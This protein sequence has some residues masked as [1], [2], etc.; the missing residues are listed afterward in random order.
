VRG[1]NLEAIT[2]LSVL[3]AGSDLLVLRHPKTLEHIRKYLAGLM[4]RTDLV[5][6]GLDLSLPAPT[7]P[8][9]A[10]RAAAVPAA[11]Q[12]RPPEVAIE[13][14]EAKPEEEPAELPPSERRPEQPTRPEPLP[15]A[16]AAPAP[17]R[18]PM[19]QL[20]A[21]DIQGL[22]EMVAVFKAVKQLIAGVGPEAP[23]EAPL[24]P[25]VLPG[26]PAAKEEASVA[27]AP[28][29]RKETGPVDRSQHTL[30]PATPEG[31][32]RADEEG[33]A[34]A[35]HHAQPRT[36]CAIDKNGTC[37]K[38]CNMG[39]CCLM[40]PEGET[41]T[42]EERTERIGLCGAT[43]ET[44]AARNFARMI[45]AGSAAH[46]DHGRHVAHT[47]LYAAKGEL[48][49]YQI[50][51]IPKL[52]AVA[53]DLGVG[54]EGRE[55][56]DIAVEVGEKALSQYGRQDGELLYIKRAPL[57]LQEIWR[58]EGV[59]PP[60]IDRSV[61]EVMNI[62][63]MAVNQDMEQVV[64]LATECALADGW[65]ASMMATD[66]SD[67]LFGT[68]VP[69]LGK[70]NL[71]YMK[72]DTVNIIVHGHEPSLSEMIVQ[73]VQDP[74]MIAYAKSKGALG[75]I[76]LGGICCTSDEILIRH[77]IPIVGN[78]LQQELAISTGALEA[79]VVDVQSV[80]QGVADPAKCFHTQIVT[81]GPIAK[82]Q[83]AY[84]HYNYDESHALEIARSIVR[85]AIDNFPKRDKARVA[86]PAEQQE[87]VVGFSHEAIN[88]ML[89]GM[90][91]ASYRPLNDNIINGRVRGLAGIVG[92]GNAR[93]KQDDLY[94][95]WAKELI[96]N[97]VLVLAT[98]CSA[99]ALGKAGLLVPE[100]AQKAGDGLAEVCEMVGMPPCL[101][102]GACVD[103][104]RILMAASA[105][106][107]EGGLGDHISDIPAAIGIFPERMSEKA[108]S[109]GQCFVASGAYVL[110]AEGFPTVSESVCTNY[111]LKDIEKIYGGKWDF[112]EG[113]PYE[114]AK[115]CI[116]HI[117]S[118]RKAL[119]IDK[120]RT[121]VLVD[122]AMRRE[123]L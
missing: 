111:L 65:G 27:V 60:G 30:G 98:G 81:T 6:M 80:M 101:H 33:C 64:R 19:P 100:A 94:V 16:A 117:D 74:G 95:T 8:A 20:T 32:K 116:A 103:S 41:E 44:I 13:R 87:M 37:C 7:V 78:Y 92:C 88:Y 123:L 84:K 86:I 59:I 43:S 99:I 97:D 58:R 22:K 89:G 46:S 57:K 50:K 52:L 82:M 56:K 70:V 90:F 118:K 53:M 35:F 66:L 28:P 29:K 26:P 120:A 38:L 3:Q 2:A 25:P 4:I 93:I 69:I 107:R 83:G 75:G 61:V 24:A 76:S 91:R 108:V 85:D 15:A 106:V 105:V 10:P 49:D 11:E 72:E 121:R 114:M 104:S 113:D 54:T 62:A 48:P 55:I 63:H 23:G 42:P 77:G 18:E 17:E 51:D 5:S 67:I 36:A 79:M 9:A 31:L 40:P 112:V 21:Q 39:P 119:G 73:A 45:A 122:M 14:F 110:F 109:I 115:R 47:F 102:M 71:G 34:T 68:P 12:A 1:I 96:Q